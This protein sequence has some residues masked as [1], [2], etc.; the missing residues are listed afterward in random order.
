[1]DGFDKLKAKVSVGGSA[2]S[3]FV[4]IETTKPNLAEVLKLV[5]DI[6]KNPGFPESELDILRKESIA[7][8]EEGRSEPE[9]VA[10]CIFS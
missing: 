8:I 4:N 9:S 6:L 7:G 5:K 10:N 1:M 2:I 3:S